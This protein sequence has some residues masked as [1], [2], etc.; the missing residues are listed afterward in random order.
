MMLGEGEGYEGLSIREAQRQDDRRQHRDWIEANESLS[1]DEIKDLGRLSVTRLRSC[2]L[3][4]HAL[5]QR[6]A[7]LGLRVGL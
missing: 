4:T 1:C 6:L 7:H 3:H 5:A 2:D